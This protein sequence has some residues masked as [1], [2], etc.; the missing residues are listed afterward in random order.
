MKAKVAKDLMVG[1]LLFQFRFHIFPN[2]DANKE[3]F[4]TRTVN[5]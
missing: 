3:R 4:R 1:V 2:K 5:M